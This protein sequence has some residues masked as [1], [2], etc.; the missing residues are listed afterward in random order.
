[1]VRPEQCTSEVREHKPPDD[2]RGYG[3]PF[4]VPAP[5]SQRI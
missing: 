1:M 2:P 5:K 4:G 3:H